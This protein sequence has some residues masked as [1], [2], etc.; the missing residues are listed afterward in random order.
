[1]CYSNKWNTFV[2]SLQLSACVQYN[3]MVVNL[4]SDMVTSGFAY[5]HVYHKCF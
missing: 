3:D 4:E 2:P 5:Y 1:M